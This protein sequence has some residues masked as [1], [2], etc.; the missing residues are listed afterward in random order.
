VANTAAWRA[1]LSLAMA[2]PDTAAPI[3]KRQANVAERI[4]ALAPTEEH[5][6]GRE[7]TVQACDRT[8]PHDLKML[9]VGHGGHRRGA[10]VAAQLTPALRRFQVA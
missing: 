6:Q 5:I 8:P 7:L 1:R 2:M 10:L 4:C 9:M 3:K